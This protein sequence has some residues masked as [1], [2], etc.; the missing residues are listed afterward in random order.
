N[1]KRIHPEA[2]IVRD[3]AGTCRAAGERRHHGP[4]VR[5]VLLQT[6]GDRI[7]DLR[8]DGADHDVSQLKQSKSYVHRTGFLVLSRRTRSAG[9]RAFAPRATDGLEPALN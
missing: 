8:V 4:R 3:I 2:G 9:I 6:L 1:L 5:R 7:E